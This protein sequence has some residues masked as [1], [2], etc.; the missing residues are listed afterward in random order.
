MKSVTPITANDV[1]DDKG[2][3]E[4]KEAI[5]DLTEVL[6]EDKVKLKETYEAPDPKQYQDGR[7]GIVNKRL[8]DL[9]NNYAWYK[10]DGTEAT[11]TKINEVRDKNKEN[12]LQKLDTN[13]NPGK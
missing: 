2:S 5:G 3:K 8:I 13:T 12:L 4:L 1:D 11:A 10:Y 9:I 7:R 6:G